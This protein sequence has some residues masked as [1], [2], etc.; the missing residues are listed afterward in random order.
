MLVYEGVA[1]GARR[2]GPVASVRLERLCSGLQVRHTL[3]PKPYNL[4]VRNPKP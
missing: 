3:N 4:R 1:L 2:V